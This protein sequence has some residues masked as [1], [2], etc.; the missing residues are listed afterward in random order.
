MKEHRSIVHS[1]RNQET[2]WSYKSHTDQF[3]RQMVAQ[4]IRSQDRLWS[5][6]DDTCDGVRLQVAM[7]IKDVSLLSCMI[8]DQCDRVRFVTANR[9]DGYDNL[10]A[11]LSVERLRSIRLLLEQRLFQ[12]D[13]EHADII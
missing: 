7:R 4:R 10:M 5:M 9:I 3:I 13:D 12:I 1:T 2:L 11:S 8:G 6:R